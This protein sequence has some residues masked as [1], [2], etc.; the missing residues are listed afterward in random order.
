MWID[1]AGIDNRLY[2]EHAW[3]PRR[4]KVYAEIPGQKESVPVSLAVS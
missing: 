1:E 2:R 3:A 4:Q